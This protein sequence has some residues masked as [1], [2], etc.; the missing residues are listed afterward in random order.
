MHIKKQYNVSFKREHQQETIIYLALW[1][2]LFLAPVMSIL[3]RN[4]NTN[5]TFE[6]NED[7]DNYDIFD[8]WEKWNF[9]TGEWETIS[10]DPTMVINTYS[11]PLTDLTVIRPAYHR[12]ERMCH[13]MVYGGWF[14]IDGEGDVPHN[15]EE[16][17]IGTRI[18]LVEA[19]YDGDL[20]FMHFLEHYSG[21]TIDHYTT[22]VLDGDVEAE[23]EFESFHCIVNAET[24]NYEGG[25]IYF[26][27]DPQ[28]GQM[29]VQSPDEVYYGDTVTL[30]AVSDTENG[31]TDGDWLGWYRVEYDDYG[32]EQW[33]LLSADMTAEI[34][35][36]QDGTIQAVWN[37][38][39]VPDVGPVDISEWILVEA[40]G[41]FAAVRRYYGEEGG[42]GPAACNAYSTLN[43][44]SWSEL[45]LF[46][47]PS[48]GVAVT[49]WTV[50]YVDPDTE[51]EV[52]ETFE[53]YDEYRSYWLD[54]YEHYL[55]S[56]VH[57]TASGE[58][59]GL[60]GDADGDGA[61]NV[62]DIVC[63]KKYIAGGIA[64]IEFNCADLDGDGA[65]SF[66]DLAL[67]KKLIAG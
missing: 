6:W 17:P 52:T 20:M 40:E 28:E 4:A 9:D 66:K 53:V 41:G 31:Y 26:A 51:E 36:T 57:F 60:P 30:C 7:N 65:V 10:T 12:D 45:M 44:E 33:I 42:E 62:K 61:L 46:D 25:F 2:L 27:D 14:C 19:P 43:V 59:E 38:G 8:A 37:N 56:V 50:T 1:T 47:D 49:E 39:G 48:D 16:V 21:D 11:D 5:M 34:E 3:I 15:N 54:N 29:W 24:F 18:Y 58:P 55:G 22:F 23:A 67:L 64:E 32:Q 35:I 13:V 63:M